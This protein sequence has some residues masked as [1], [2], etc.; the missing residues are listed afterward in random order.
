MGYKT[1]S[2]IYALTFGSKEKEQTGMKTPFD[3]RLSGGLTQKFEGKPFVKSEKEKKKPGAY[4][5]GAKLL[6]ETSQNDVVLSGLTSQDWGTRLGTSL[7][8]MVN[9]IRKNKKQKNLSEGKGSAV[10]TSDNPS[11]NNISIPVAGNEGPSLGTPPSNSMS[12]SYFKTKIA[13]ERANSYLGSFKKNKSISTP[14]GKTE[15]LNID[16]VTPIKTKPV[17]PFVNPTKNIGIVPRKEKTNKELKKHFKK[18]GRKKNNKKIDKN[19]VTSI[20]QAEALRKAKDR[21]GSNKE[22]IAFQGKNGYRYVL[23]THQKNK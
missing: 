1:K 6:D 13:A 11:N 18:E 12:D 5:Q 17:S 22:F 16:V 7:G 14:K 20:S 8:I 15:I 23:D 10:G 3:V 2:M 9:K 19:S 21:W 4:S